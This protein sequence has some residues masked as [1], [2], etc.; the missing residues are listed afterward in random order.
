MKNISE[1]QQNNNMIVL[2]LYKGHDRTTTETYN[3]LSKFTEDNNY[4]PV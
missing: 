1:Q 3:D 4:Q 2:N